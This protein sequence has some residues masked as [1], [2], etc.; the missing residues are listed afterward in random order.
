L[1][2]CIAA[3]QLVSWSALAGAAL[4]APTA[5]APVARSTVLAANRRRRETGVLW[6]VF[7][8]FSS[9][10]HCPLWAVFTCQERSATP[11]PTLF[12]REVLRDVRPLGGD[13]HLAPVC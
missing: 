2:Y 5:T 6:L 3:C 9:A 10:G 7:M 11:V 12:S 8:V 1:Q 13:D 4:S